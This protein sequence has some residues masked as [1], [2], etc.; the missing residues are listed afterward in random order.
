M[1]RQGARAVVVE[2][3]RVLVI[4]RLK[5]GSWYAVIPG[6]GVE[7]GETFAEA[8]V[9]ELGEETSLVAEPVRLLWDDVDDRQQFF[10]MGPAVGSLALGGPEAAEQA[11]DNRHVPTWVEVDRLDEVD[12][13]PAALRPMI[14]EL[15]TQGRG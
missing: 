7:D 5:N 13:R 8:A 6:G 2:D 15:V 1:A 10:L 9:R 14:I 12:L 11:A 4:R 3:G